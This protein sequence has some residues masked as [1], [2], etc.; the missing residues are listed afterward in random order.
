M[1][2]L[3]GLKRLHLSVSAAFFR[4]CEKCPWEDDFDP[5]DYEGVT[6][7]DILRSLRGLREFSLETEP[8]HESHPERKAK[9]LKCIKGLEDLVKAEV[10]KP[11]LQ[12]SDVRFYRPILPAREQTSDNHLTPSGRH[13]NAMGASRTTIPTTISGA[14]IP[15]TEQDL[16]RLIQQS[17]QVL[18]AWMKSVKEHNCV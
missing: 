18:L 4:D 3:I 2:Y 6:G 13:M 1:Y 8:V 16:K 7:L 11:A 12:S 10:T 14:E 15:E 17:P 9:W 5:V